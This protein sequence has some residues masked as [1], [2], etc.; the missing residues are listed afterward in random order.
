MPT[1]SS[2]TTKVNEDYSDTS[3]S[4]SYNFDDFCNTTSYETL[5]VFNLTV[6]ILGLIS[7]L[8]LMVIIAKN[9]RLRRDKYLFHNNM[10]VSSF[11]LLFVSGVMYVEDALNPCWN[12]GPFLCR[13]VNFLQT[14]LTNATTLFFIVLSIEQLNRYRR[15][16]VTVLNST[17]A[18]SL[19]VMAL[20]WIFSVI[21]SI[22]EF[23]FATVLLYSS[24]LKI[25]ELFVVHVRQSYF[26]SAKLLFVEY[27]APLLILTLVTATTGIYIIVH[28][29]RYTTWGTT[30]GESLV[31]R[32]REYPRYYW[33]VVT[34]TVI[35]VV[36]YFPLYSSEFW[37]M[38]LRTTDILYLSHFWFH[39]EA[40]STFFVLLPPASISVLT[41]FLSWEHFEIVKS[42]YKDLTVEEPSEEN[43]Q[44]KDGSEEFKTNENDLEVVS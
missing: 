35:F 14:C 12:A 13:A 10:I 20:I 41:V 7:S 28:K 9:P 37:T 6:T 1:S 36:G 22:P 34:L 31:Q 44:Q 26:V 24:R 27:I 18:R 29:S 38:L 4:F 8:F 3:W 17:H 40:I 42:I 32:D 33:F 43:V 39:V 2:P 16:T 5:A 30:A 25:C 11:F 23:I 19:L 15:K 21:V